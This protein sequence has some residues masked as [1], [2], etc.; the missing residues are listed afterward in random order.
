[1]SIFSYQPVAGHR[2]R[3]SWDDMGVSGGDVGTGTSGA[4]ALQYTR[5]LEGV[6]DSMEADHRAQVPEEEEEQ[7]SGQHSDFQMAEF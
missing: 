4:L 3:V 2:G 7:V 5:H 6:T 1:M